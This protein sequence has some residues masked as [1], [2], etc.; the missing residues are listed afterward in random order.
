MRV[1]VIGCEKEIVIRPGQKQRS[2]QNSVE[3][4]VLSATRMLRPAGRWT[5]ERRMKIIYSG[6]EAGR[7]S[8]Y[9]LIWLAV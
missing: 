4:Q 7:R 6:G 1:L 8:L 5:G 3:A 9:E 2:R